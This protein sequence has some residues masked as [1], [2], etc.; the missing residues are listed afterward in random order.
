M[1][2]FSMLWTNR[3]NVVGREVRCSSKG[4]STQVHPSIGIQLV[5]GIVVDAEK[6]E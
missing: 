2:N 5:G 6:V 3:D 1:M 4:S